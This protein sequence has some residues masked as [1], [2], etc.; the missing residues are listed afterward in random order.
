[1]IKSQNRK[2]YSILKITGRLDASSSF[3]AAQ[4]LE[5]LIEKGTIY[6]ILD[7]SELTFLSSPGVKMIEK[8][9]NIIESLGGEILIVGAKRFVNDILKLT[10]MDQ[11]YKI[12]NTLGDA[13]L[14]FDK[15]VLS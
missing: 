11:K 1:M 12:F 7:L 2:F 6:V 3:K 14:I 4:L 13:V 5:K 10:G 15:L 9:N 8:H